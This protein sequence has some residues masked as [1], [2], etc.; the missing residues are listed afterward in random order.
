MLTVPLITD[1]L[2]IA[3]IHLCMRSYSHLNSLDISDMAQDVGS[4]TIEV[5]IGSD[6]YWQLVESLEEMMA[7]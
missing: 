1:N 6:Y 7:L 2:A 4:D 3:P 5:L